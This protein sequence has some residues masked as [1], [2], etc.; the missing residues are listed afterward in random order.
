MFKDLTIDVH[1]WKHGKWSLLQKEKEWA[2][3]QL[4]EEIQ[5]LYKHEGPIW[6]IYGSCKAISL[7]EE[8]PLAVYT[9]CRMGRASGILSIEKPG[10]NKRLFFSG[11]LVSSVSHEACWGSESLPV[12]RV[13][14]MRVQ[15]AQD[16]YSGCLFK[17]TGIHSWKAG[18]APEKW[19]EQLNGENLHRRLFLNECQESW[20]WLLWTW[21]PCLQGF[22]LLFWRTAECLGGVGGPDV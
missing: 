9:L 5:H 15:I 20:G 11:S 8:E 3:N 14:V 17:L 6:G 12:E 1:Y 19:S 10:V 7:R 2:L 16:Q 4:S 21:P 13:L 18:E 22:D